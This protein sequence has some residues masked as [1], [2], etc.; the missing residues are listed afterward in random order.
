MS[1]VVSLFLPFISQAAQI[2]MYQPPLYEGTSPIF[3]LSD[4]FLIEG[5]G[6]GG[7]DH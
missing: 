2:S 1:T 7:S 6:R 5:Q 4:F 3:L